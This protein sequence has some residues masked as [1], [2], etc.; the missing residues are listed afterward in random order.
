MA[1]V[2]S[3]GVPTPMVQWWNERMWSTEPC[4]E[5]NSYDTH[6]TNC[7]PGR[8]YVVCWGCRLMGPEGETPAAAL[9]KWNAMPRD[10]GRFVT[11]TSTGQVRHEGEL[12]EGGG[13]VSEANARVEGPM[14]PHMIK[15]GLVGSGNPEVQC[16]RIRG[17]VGPHEG[18]GLNWYTKDI[19]SEC[20]AYK[21]TKLVNQVIDDPNNQVTSPIDSHYTQL[22]SLQPRDAIASWSPTWTG[23]TAFALGNIVKLAARYFT[24]NT[25][26][27]N[28]QGLKF[29]VGELERVLRE[30]EDRQAAKKEDR[31]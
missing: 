16:Q 4:P 23:P 22:G 3:I 10:V 6:F 15:V 31:S 12:Y 7:G 13:E 30:E 9:T 28:L 29:Y 14:C 27:Y 1:D 21:A 11:P 26:R 2:S 17:H 18:N 19:V 25:P 8:I 5:C 24:K 20:G